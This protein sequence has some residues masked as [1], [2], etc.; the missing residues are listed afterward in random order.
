MRSRGAAD[1]AGTACWHARR[2]SQHWRLHDSSSS[3]L[4][5]RMRACMIAASITQGSRRWSSSLLD[6]WRMGPH[7]LPAP[8][9][10][11]VFV[12]YS[13]RSS[14]HRILNPQAL[15]R[16]TRDKERLVL[17]ETLTCFASTPTTGRLQPTTLEVSR[18]ASAPTNL[19]LN[20][21]RA[22]DG[23]SIVARQAGNLASSPPTTNHQPPFLTLRRA[24]PSLVVSPHQAAVPTNHDHDHHHLHLTPTPLPTT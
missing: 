20:D 21:A 17:G 4:W 8:R 2:G 7:A 1:S 12:C 15:R 5:S 6:T 9:S 3:C 11:V 22:V 13:Y 18:P 16:E 14:N 19:A 24:L 10:Y 23:D